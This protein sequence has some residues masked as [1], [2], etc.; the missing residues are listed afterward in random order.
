MQFL[1]L[2]LTLTDVIQEIL[3]TSKCRMSW[4]VVL[5]SLGQPVIN[6]YVDYS[7]LTLMA[8]ALGLV[9]YAQGFAVRFTL[10][11]SWPRM[12]L[13]NFPIDLCYR[14]ASGLLVMEMHV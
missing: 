4:S 7:P 11:A 5:E 8:F 13:A 12:Y 10:P 14:R 9:S 1:K 6:R 3:G 2:S